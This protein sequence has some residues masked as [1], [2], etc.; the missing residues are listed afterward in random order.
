MVRGSEEEL[1]E[2]FLVFPSAISPGCKKEPLLQVSVTLCCLV[3]TA[4]D[5]SDIF[6]F[7]GKNL[8]LHGSVKRKKFRSF[9][10]PRK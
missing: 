3:E 1:Y 9:H 5:A 2:H 4:A 6:D 7:V 10:I 8:K